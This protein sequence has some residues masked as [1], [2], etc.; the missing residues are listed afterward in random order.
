MADVLPPRK[1]R[2]TRISTAP[3]ETVSR[4]VHPDF[5]K[6][7]PSINFPGGTGI[8][9]DRS[10]SFVA[11]GKAEG[12]SAS[13]T[14]ERVAEYAHAPAQEL[15]KSQATMKQGLRG[16]N[17]QCDAFGYSNASSNITPNLTSLMQNLADPTL[18]LRIQS[19]PIL[20][21]LVWIQ[22]IK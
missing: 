10:T 3:E 22:L 21:N 18:H 20:E 13:F 1:R 17:A 4:Q 14:G 5:N 11:N 9:S 19:L 2:R 16:S 7:A 6:G 12:H 8:T 15:P